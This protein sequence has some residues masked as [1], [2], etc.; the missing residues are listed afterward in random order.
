MEIFFFATKHNRSP[1][2]VNQ[3]ILPCLKYLNSISN[4]DN[5][6]ENIDD[7]DDNDNNN[8]KSLKI[9]P[10]EGK[11]NINI[12]SLYNN[13]LFNN[14]KKSAEIIHIN[15]NNNNIDYKLIRKYL[16]LWKNEAKILND[17]LR[18]Q[19]ILSDNWLIDL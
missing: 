1:E 15:D 11:S 8:D 6:N 10:L 4:I 17:D 14:W 12:S 18:N 7:N 3:L 19:P 2:I 9:I 16:T 5:N 13:P